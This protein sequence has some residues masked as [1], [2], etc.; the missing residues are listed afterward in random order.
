MSKCV[1]AHTSLPDRD[2]AL[3]ME[4]N[5]ETTPHIPFPWAMTIIAA[6]GGLNVCVCVVCDF[7]SVA[8]IN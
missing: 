7:L 2:S 8:Q 3:C 1:F 5:I 6:L 4:I